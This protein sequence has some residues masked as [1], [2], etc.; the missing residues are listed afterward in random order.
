MTPQDADT[1]VGGQQRNQPPLRLHAILNTHLIVHFARCFSNSIG[2]SLQK[3]NQ[4]QSKVK[5]CLLESYLVVRNVN[6]RT[7]NNAKIHQVILICFSSFFVFIWTPF[8]F[9]SVFESTTYLKFAKLQYVSSGF[10]CRVI[11]G[12]LM[13]LY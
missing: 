3:K 9:I 13:R 11:A 12:S 5:Y 8:C 6:K 2:V 4:N 10:R 7:Y 1:Q